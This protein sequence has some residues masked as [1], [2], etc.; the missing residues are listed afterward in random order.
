V[1]DAVERFFVGMAVVGF[2]G[3]FVSVGWSM[4]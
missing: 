1:M 3:L 4:F 2:I